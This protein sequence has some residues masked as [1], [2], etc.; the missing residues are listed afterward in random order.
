MDDRRTVYPAGAIAVAGNSIVAVGP[1]SEILVA[2][3]GRRVLDARGAAVHPGFVESHYHATLHTTRGTV[4]DAPHAVDPSG[5]DGTNIG[6]YSAWF[7]NLDD[8]DEYASAL[9]ACVEMV[10]NGITCFMEPGTVFETDAVASAAEA[11]GVR[12]SLADPFLWDHADGLAMANEITRAPAATERSMDSLGGELRRN[13]DPD[14][15]VTGHVA[16]YGM[17]TFTDELAVA[18]KACADEA[19][20]SLT[21]HQNFEAS[22]V[23]YDDSRFGRHAIDHLHSLGVLGDNVTLAHMNLLRDDEVEALAESGAAVVWHPGNY[24]FYGIAETVPCRFPELAERGVPLAFM[25]DAAKV[26]SFGEMAW[27][28]YLVA[29]MNG[30]FLASESIFEMQTRGGAAAV[31]L[32]DRIGSLESGKRADFVIRSEDLPE[33]QPGI[34][35]VR[36]IAL[37]S[38]SKSVDTVVIDGEIVV[39][40]GRLTRLDEG[41]VYEQARS[42]ARRLAE[43]I[44][45]PPVGTWPEVR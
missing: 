20:V 4:S 42:S 24:L 23:G 45:L 37:V 9:L 29:R 31:G 1:E 36:E 12:A 25:T 15:L 28:G 11:V 2:W 39:R 44:G 34:D 18:A 14:A 26:W 8:D 13:A 21:L 5:G 33:A 40:R 6:V 32:A 10:Q 16:L 17:G 38:R 41:V 22:D 30:S 7:N 27:L 35:P 19:G 43:K 3:R